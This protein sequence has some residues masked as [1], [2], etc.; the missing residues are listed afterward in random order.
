MPGAATLF[1]GG[2]V[3]GVTAPGKGRREVG[4]GGGGADR[5]VDARK[6]AIG[7]VFLERDAGRE[8]RARLPDDGGALAGDQDPQELVGHNLDVPS[9]RRAPVE[10]LHRARPLEGGELDVEV[11][12]LVGLRGG[13]GR[14]RGLDVLAARVVGRQELAR[15]LRLS[16]G[17]S[18][19]GIDELQLLRRVLHPRLAQLL[20]GR[21]RLRRRLRRDALGLRDGLLAQSQLLLALLHDLRLVL[22]L[23]RHRREG[24]LRLA[25]LPHRGAGPR[26]RREQ[27]HQKRLPEQTGHDRLLLPPQRELIP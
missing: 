20:A 15:R 5:V 18:D 1:V 26:E 19:D 4:S 23:R 9:A 12:G 24:L 10:L 7:P 11:D 14:L 6:E 16:L 17:A 13:D 25:D 22:L 27:G 3:Y 2:D 8:D 21:R